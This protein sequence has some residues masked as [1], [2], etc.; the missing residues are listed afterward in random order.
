MRCDQYIGL[1]KEAR[2]WVKRN[3]DKNQ[4]SYYDMA[5][6]AFDPEP[7]QGYLIQDDESIYKEVVQCSPWS[8]GPMY[9]TCIGAFNKKNELIGYMFQWKENP[10]MT[11]EYD[12]EKG[13]FYV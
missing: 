5:E 4:I 10:N 6:Q 12:M 1:T 2:E 9:F 13:E 7:L 8:S 11:D 3:F